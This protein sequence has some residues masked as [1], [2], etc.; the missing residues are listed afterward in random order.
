MTSSATSAKATTSARRITGGSSAL[1]SGSGVP[2]G[3][4]IGKDTQLA[5]PRAA[6]NVMRVAELARPSRALI[7]H[8]P[9]RR[10]KFHRGNVKHVR[11]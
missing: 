1:L 6:T 8:N 2:D 11:G 7:R 10:Q 3:A 9:R 4:L 5:L